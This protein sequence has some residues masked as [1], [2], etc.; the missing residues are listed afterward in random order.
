VHRRRL[1]CAWRTYLRRWARARLVTPPSVHR[2]QATT[3]NC[4]EVRRY[5]P[6]PQ[7]DMG[8]APEQP[9][10]PLGA[11]GRVAYRPSFSKA[12]EPRTLTNNASPSTMPMRLRCPAR[13]VTP[14]RCP[15]SRCPG[16]PR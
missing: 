15:R 9:S 5:M 4:G 11:T 13:L 8:G 14:R 10:T 6:R 12:H 2:R 1:A 3:E 7:A 16:A